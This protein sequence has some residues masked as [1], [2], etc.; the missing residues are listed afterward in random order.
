MI[1][2]KASAIDSLILVGIF[3]SPRPGNSITIAP[4]RGLSVGQGILAAIKADTLSL[5]AWQI[6]MYGFMAVG[7]FVIFRAALGTRL[8]TDTPE[9][10][11]MMQIAML[12]GFATAYPV[13]W[14]LIRAGWKEAM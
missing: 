5:T 10:W 8:E 4:M 3:T 14:W 7:H 9:F 11:F 1:R 12:C 13:N 6:G 2:V